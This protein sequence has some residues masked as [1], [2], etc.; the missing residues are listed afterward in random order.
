[1]A[2]FTVTTSEYRLLSLDNDLPF[3][4]AFCN[5]LSVELAQ[6]STAA[7][8]KEKTDFI[9]TISHELRSPLHGIL[10]SCELLQ[11]GGLSEEQKQ[12]LEMVDSCG[13]TLLD[14][15]NM[16]LDW[17]KVNTFEQSLEA[18]ASGPALADGKGRRASIAQAQRLPNLYGHVDLAAVVEEVVEGAVLAQTYQNVQA[19]DFADLS[20][21]ARGRDSQRGFVKKPNNQPGS[22]SSFH[23]LPVEVALQVSKAPAS[24]TYYTQPGAFRRVVM[25]LVGNVS[26]VSVS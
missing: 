7:A 18:P 4:N 16:V 25:S 17:S 8:D 14:T 11:T 5:C 2:V 26:H 19:I 22:L 12:T 24:W 9:G 20:S 1:M 10:A 15:I 3:L 13:R 6:L 23:K 21:Q